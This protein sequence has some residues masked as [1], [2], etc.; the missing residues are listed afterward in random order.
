MNDLFNNIVLVMD[1]LGSEEVI[2]EFMLED[3]SD[4]ALSVGSDIDLKKF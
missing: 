1:M 3:N 2:E 4:G